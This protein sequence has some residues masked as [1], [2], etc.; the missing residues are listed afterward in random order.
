MGLFDFLK[1]KDELAMPD[2]ASSEFQQTIA[3]S[4]LPGSTGAAGIEAG[5]W[6]SVE[7]LPTQT[8]DLSGSDAREEMLE[9]LRRHGVDPEQ[10]GQTV[11]PS[12]VPGLQEEILEILQRHGVDLDASGNQPPGGQPPAS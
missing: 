2:P 3:A 5:E 10:E 6:Q 9:L 8:V 12:Q 4:E 1:R 11:D 7:S